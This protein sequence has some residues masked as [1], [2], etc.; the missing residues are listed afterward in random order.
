[1]L[2]CTGAQLFVWHLERERVRAAW[3]SFFQDWD[4]LLSPAFHTPAFEH[5]DCTGPALGGA[6]VDWKVQVA[7]QSVPYSR[8]LFFPHVS[9]LA[10][11]PAL[12]CPAGLNR[13]GL[14]LA[15]QLIGPYLEDWT[16]TR[17]ASLLA[18]EMGGFSAPPAFA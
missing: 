18:R 8:G 6:A 16:L 3:R 5:I 10:G 7:G 15:V 11:Q 4:A 14:P 17:L 12:T 1:G 9:T 13:D 2:T